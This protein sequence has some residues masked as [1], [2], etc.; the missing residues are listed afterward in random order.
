MLASSLFQNVSRRGLFIRALATPN[1]NSL[2]F[3]PGKPV[4][5]DP[6]RSADFPKIRDAMSAPLARQLFQIEGV[7]R[8]FYGADFIS[9]TKRGELD[10]AVLK[11]EIL[12]VM[13]EHFARGQPLFTAELDEPQDTKIGEGDS[14]RLANVKEI[15]ATRVRPFV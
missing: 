8:V 4:T 15:L 13:T 11:P 12:S 6:K 1:P 2:M 5:G 3:N 7:I 10:W 9:V 14:E